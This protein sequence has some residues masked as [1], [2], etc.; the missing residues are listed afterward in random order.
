MLTNDELCNDRYFKIKFKITINHS[1]KK[2]NLKNKKQNREKKERKRGQGKD[3][4]MGIIFLDS[5]KYARSK[6][7]RKRHD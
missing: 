1:N 7:N 6:K 4:R 5:Q 3:L 2:I